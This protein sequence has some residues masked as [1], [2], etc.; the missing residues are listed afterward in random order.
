MSMAI[1][2]EIPDATVI[3]LPRMAGAGNVKR[4]QGKRTDS[5]F[6]Q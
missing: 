3:G 1:E 6:S 5:I 4:T 2:A